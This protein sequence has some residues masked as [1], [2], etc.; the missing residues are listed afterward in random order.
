MKHKFDHMLRD[1]IK[2]TVQAAASTLFGLEVIRFQIV[3]TI[4][5]VTQKRE[6]DFMS[7]V[8]LAEG[9]DELLHVEFQTTDDPDMVFRMR[10]YWSLYQ[11]R[12][13]LPMQQYVVYIGEKPS[14]MATKLRQAIP[15]EA[16]DY[17]YHLLELRTFDYEKLLESEVPE[18]IVLAVLANYNSKSSKQVIEQIV[19]S[20][21]RC[22]SSTTL[23]QKYLR[24]LNHFSGLR[25]LDQ[26]TKQIIE[27]MP[28]EYDYTQ[29]VLYKDGEVEGL[30][31]SKLIY[32]A[33]QMGQSSESIAAEHGITKAEVL[34]LK[35]TFGL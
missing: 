9:L 22:A 20:L 34:D 6:T 33:L 21:Q 3:D 13:R 26:Q 12:Y 19:K 23:L 8:T 2:E 18:A 7:I 14:A 30:N 1:N 16:Q 35:N 24:Q 17:R 5:T 11:D 27:A 25:N 32:K 15:R 28:I 31:K 10:N 4:E 29:H